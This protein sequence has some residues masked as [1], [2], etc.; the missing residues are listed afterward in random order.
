MKHFKNYADDRFNG[1]CVYCG[2]RPET[3]EHVPPKV[4]LDK[5]YPA[6]LQVVEACKE[7]NQGFSVDEQYMACLLDCVISGSADPEA[8][9]RQSIRRTL[10]ARPA[11]AKRLRVARRIVGQ[12]TIFDVEFD[13]IERVVRKMA[14]C[15]VLYELNLLVPTKEAQVWSSPFC[16]LRAKDASGFEDLGA[17]EMA[18]WPEVGSR[19]MQRLIIPDGS[20]ENGWIHVQPGRYRYAV[21][22]SDDIEVRMV[23]SEYL[24]CEVR[25]A[26]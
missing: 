6:E 13:R 10:A 26:Q 25:W 18:L 21:T 15:H 20:Y 12:K 23:F 8:L 1:Q 7:C 2:E 24:A 17:G 22:Q 9:Q 16:S 4:F 5:P 3:R 14:M 11:L 19:A